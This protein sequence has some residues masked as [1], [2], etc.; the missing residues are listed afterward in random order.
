VRELRN[1]Y[2]ALKKLPDDV[3]HQ[4]PL[5]ILELPAKISLNTLPRITDESRIVTPLGRS[6]DDALSFFTL[7]WNAAGPDIIVTGPPGSGKTNLLHAA[8][9]TAAKQYSPDDVRFLPVDFNRRSLR[10]VAGLKHVI[11]RVTDSADLRQQLGFLQQEM[12]A[13]AED[14]PHGQPLLFPA[15][16]IVID[17]YDAFA[18]AL[19]SEQDILRLMRDLLRQFGDNGLYIWAAGYLERTTDPLMKQMLLRR[20]GFALMTRESLQKLYVRIAGISAE[21]M[22]EGRAY[23]AQYNN[24]NVVQTALVENLPAVVTRINEQWTEYPPAGW[25]YAGEDAAPVTPTANSGAASQAQDLEID[26]AGLIQDLL[27]DS[28]NDKDE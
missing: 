10:G 15:T 18:E 24:I 27:G 8:M 9:L 23:F 28:S 11:K 7:D 22:P 2:V 3:P 5:P 20:S 26:T 19:A 6:D 13:L 12:A 17:D 1:G 14:T 16:V 4:S 25:W 21:A